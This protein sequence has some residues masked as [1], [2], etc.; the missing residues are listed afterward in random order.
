MN[1]ESKNKALNRDEEKVRSNLESV[2]L[3]YTLLK[4]QS[5]FFIC[6]N[7]MASC[8]AVKGSHILLNGVGV[9]D[10]QNATKT[11]RVGTVAETPLFPE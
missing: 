10:M 6:V 11:A 5:C 7:T 3:L 2:Y 9:A 8:S 1:V 4:S